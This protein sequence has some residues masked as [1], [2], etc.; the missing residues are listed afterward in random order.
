MNERDKLL[1]K[2]HKSHIR[3]IKD[4]Y[5]R[6]RNQVNSM[7]RTA[8][9]NYTRTLLNKILEHKKKKYIPVEIKKMLSRT[10]L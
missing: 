10:I 9:S 7:I 5:K 3:A 6:K 2:S 8:K 4:E 1:R